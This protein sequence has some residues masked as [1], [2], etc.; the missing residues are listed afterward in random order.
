MAKQKRLLTWEEYTSL[1]TMG[2]EMHDYWMENKPKMYRELYESGELLPILN[3][4]GDEQDDWIRELMQN[5]MDLAGARELARSEFIDEMSEASWSQD[6]IHPA[7]IWDKIPAG[8]SPGTR[9]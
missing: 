4:R 2:R 9:K 3:R 1:S 5:G 6:E 8:Q 7:E